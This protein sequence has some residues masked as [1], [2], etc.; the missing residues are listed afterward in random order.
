MLGVW[1]S[2]GETPYLRSHLNFGCYTGNWE[3]FQ[4]EHLLSAQAFVVALL[5]KLSPFFMVPSSK[6]PPPFFAANPLLYHFGVESS[7]GPCWKDVCVVNALAP[8]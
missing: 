5:P 4:F 2:K 3:E 1:G 8:T 7:L 6:C